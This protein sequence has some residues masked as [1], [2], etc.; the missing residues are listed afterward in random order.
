MQTTQNKPRRTVS[1]DR[2]F[3]DSPDETWRSTNGGEE[4]RGGDPAGA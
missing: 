2:P 4:G 1:H 3:A